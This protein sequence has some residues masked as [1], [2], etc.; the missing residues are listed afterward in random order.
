MVVFLLLEAGADDVFDNEVLDV[1]LGGRDT[2]P[3]CL[4]VIWVADLLK[5]AVV[6]EAELLD[7]CFCGGEEEKMGETDHPDRGSWEDDGWC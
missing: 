2:G 4:R 6:V 1:W 5:R 7:G 3:Q